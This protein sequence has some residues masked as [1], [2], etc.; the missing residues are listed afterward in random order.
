MEHV[1][2]LTDSLRRC[3]DNPDFLQFFVDDL[4]HH[5]PDMLPLV[6]RLGHKGLQTVI[7]KGLT[8]FLLD[9]AH[10]SH[11]HQTLARLKERHGPDGL[12]IR[13]EWFDQ[14]HQSLLRAM[15]E[16]DPEFNASLDKHWDHVLKNGIDQ[17]RS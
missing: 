9:A 7:C 3:L 16:H 11:A 13:K 5:Q 8:T 1:T 6:S 17:M 12:N 15:R 14:F 4:M 2:D 10:H